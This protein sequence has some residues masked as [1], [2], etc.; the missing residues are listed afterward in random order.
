M[1]QTFSQ[2]LCLS[3][4]ASLTYALLIRNFSK[5]EFNMYL[6]NHTFIKPEMK[7]SDIINN[8]PAIMLMLEHLDL[9]ARDYEQNVSQIC[10]DTEIRVELFVSICNL[11]N[12]FTNTKISE[13]LVED[14]PVLVKVLRNSHKYY[15]EDKYPEI[16]KYIELIN[17]STHTKETELVEI[18]FK[19]Y[20]D[21]V[22][23]HL[24]YEE[25]IAFPYICNLLDKNS[26]LIAAIFSES[27]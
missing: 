13:Y 5:N 24:N 17:K 15:L 1:L 12:G 4:N 19:D 25:K 10:A 14:I 8:N 16:L 6:N 18:F 20:F 9:G 3:K 23:E 27:E 21:E 2:K 22:K 11:Y 26:N 7:L